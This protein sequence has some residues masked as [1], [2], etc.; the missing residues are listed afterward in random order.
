MKILILF[1][2]FIFTANSQ[3]SIVGSWGMCESGEIDGVI[4]MRNVCWKIR[5]EENGTGNINNFDAKFKWKIINK[6]IE[7]FAESS[8]SKVETSYFIESN[9]SVE[10]YSD[11]EFE[12]L[13]L[14]TESDY[15]Y[16]LVRK[17]V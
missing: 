1:I 7:I 9:Y 12:Y 11:S 2:G 17:K 15:Y 14:I 6:K 16:L 10:R 3:N 13:K 8:K 4:S 5:F